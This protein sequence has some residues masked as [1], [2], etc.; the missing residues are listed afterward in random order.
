MT[1][2]TSQQVPAATDREM[3]QQDSVP[4]QPNK[5][6]EAP[7]AEKWV[8]QVNQHLIYMQT[9][10][11]AWSYACVEAPEPV[12]PTEAFTSQG[13][14]EEPTPGAQ[15][16]LNNEGFGLDGLETPTG[17]V[18]GQKA[19][20]VQGLAMPDVSGLELNSLDTPGD[21]PG[22]ARKGMAM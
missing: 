4:E 1:S 22:D 21:A 13:V 7:F 9:A 20:T 5:L 15:Q 6:H 18:V 19:A 11:K 14:W 3:E 16:P 10:H 8:D 2:E 17:T 12:L